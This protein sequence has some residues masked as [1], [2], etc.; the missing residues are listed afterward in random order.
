MNKKELLIKGLKM[1]QRN[2]DTE[3]AHSIA[4]SFLLDYINDKDIRKAFE[5]IPKWY[6]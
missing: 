5:D 4:D 3:S 1:Q 6:A 2:C